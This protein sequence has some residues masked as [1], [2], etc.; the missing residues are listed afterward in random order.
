MD[1]C[2]VNTFRRDEDMFY[3]HYLNG[4]L[5]IGSGKLESAC[6]E[7]KKARKYYENSPGVKACMVACYMGDYYVLLKEMGKDDEAYYVMQ[8]AIDAFNKANSVPQ[9]LKDRFGRYQF[10][11]VRTG[12]KD[13]CGFVYH[14]AGGSVK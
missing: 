12:L 14:I 1:E 9:I 13:C 2:K 3:Y 10:M 4:C 7:F 5:Q 6:D 11:P 8:S